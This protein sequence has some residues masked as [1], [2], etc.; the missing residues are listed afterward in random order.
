MDKLRG[1]TK[2][3]T[4]ASVELA[5]DFCSRFPLNTASVAALPRL[6]PTMKFWFSVLVASELVASELVASISD[7]IEHFFDVRS[8]SSFASSR[9]Y[10]EFGFGSRPSVARHVHRLPRSTDR[11][12]LEGDGQHIKCVM[13]VGV[14]GHQL[15]CWHPVYGPWTS[16]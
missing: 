4:S 10:V 8:N 9:K 11:Q 16:G 7:P 2:Y 6:L 5:G 14:K 3:K 12:Q 13:K 1:C 15:A